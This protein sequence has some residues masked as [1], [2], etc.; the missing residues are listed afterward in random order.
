MCP[1]YD[2]CGVEGNIAV[3]LSRAAFAMIPNHSAQM[4]HGRMCLFGRGSGQQ[5]FIVKYAE[6]WINP[7]DQ[8]CASVWSNAAG[9]WLLLL[10]DSLKRQMAVVTVPPKADG[11]Q[12][13]LNRTYQRLQM[14]IIKAGLG[15]HSL[16]S[17]CAQVGR[18]LSDTVRGGC[19]GVCWALGVALGRRWG[20]ALSNKRWHPLRKSTWPSPVL[21]NEATRRHTSSQAFIGLTSTKS[22]LRQEYVPYRFHGCGKDKSYH[23]L[24]FGHIGLCC[25][26]ISW[27]QGQHQVCI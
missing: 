25:R 22:Y 9:I 19:H 21:C 12:C 8:L 18:L 17:V 10:N 11:M 3:A 2:S 20:G 1:L 6:Y 5:G 26:L 7:Q 13:V 4:C 27:S 14:I 16:H 15:H 24:W 23:T